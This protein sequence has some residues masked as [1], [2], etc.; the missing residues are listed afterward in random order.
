MA[1]I[2]IKRIYDEPSPDDGYRVLVDR[3]W[4]RGISKQHA[5]LDAWEKDIA[6]S[7]ELRKFFDH[8]E[9]KFEEFSTLYKK[10]LDENIAAKQF[11]DDISK[12]ARVTLLYG[13]RDPLINHAR[14]LEEWIK[15]NS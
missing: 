4:P 13:A 3:L 1:T 12:H 8:Q 10:E 11:I 6:P 7:N 9:N 2:S 14:V 15:E 5:K